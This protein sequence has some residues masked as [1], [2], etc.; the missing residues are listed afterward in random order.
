MRQLLQSVRSVVS[1]QHIGFKATGVK[2]AHL[3]IRGAVTSVGI[4]L[5]TPISVLLMVAFCVEFI[6]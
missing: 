1:D 2:L 3:T 6:E 4:R 5:T